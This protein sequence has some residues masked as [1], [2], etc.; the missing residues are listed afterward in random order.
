MTDCETIAF[1][2]SPPC[3]PLLAPP[4]WRIRLLI[5]LLAT[6]GPAA[7]I[8]VLAALSARNAA[9]LPFSHDPR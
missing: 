8:S 1:I 9:Q 6:I 4:M 7:L 3:P 2:S 5:M